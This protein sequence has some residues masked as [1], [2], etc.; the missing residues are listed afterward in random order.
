MEENTQTKLTQFQEFIS[1]EFNN[2]DILLQALTTPQYGNEN[3]VPHY[4]ILETLGDSVIKLIFSLIL[5]NKGIN[6]QEQLTKTKQCLESNQTFIRIA[7]KMELSKFI[8][9]SKNQ[10]IKGTSILADVFEAICGALFIDSNYNLKIIENKII[11]RFYDDW[12]NYLE[13]GIDFSKNQLLEFLQNKFKLTP[14]ISYEYEGIGPQH[15]LQWIA[16]APKVLD[17]NNKEIISLPD[18]L[19]STKF[20]TKKEAEKDLSSRILKYLEKHIG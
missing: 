20:T 13:E 9:A 19:R 4:E 17:Q 12:N 11:N 14:I 8:F 1:Y 5:Y 18:N 3:D 16:K 7:S 15:K 6:N 2:S 10:E